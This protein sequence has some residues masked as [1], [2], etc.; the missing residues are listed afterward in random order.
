NALVVD[1]PD[2]IGAMHADITRLG[3]ALLNLLSNAAKFTEGGTVSLVVRR[4]QTHGLDFV[5]FTVRDTGIGMAQEQLEKLFQDFSQA[6]AS[7]TRKFG[8]TGLGLAIAR[9]FA[10][11]MGGDITVASVPGKGS[12]FELRL[13]TGIGEA[14][15]RPLPPALPLGRTDFAPLDPL[16]LPAE[17]AGVPVLVID[18]D[19]TVRDV[20]ARF[21]TRE[22]FAPMLAA[23]GLDGLRQAKLRKP[24]AIIL[25][26]MMPDLDG[27]SVLAAVKA[28]QALEDVPVVIHSIVE[29]KNRGFA[30]GASDYWVKPFDRDR[31]RH[32]L[33]RVRLPR[34]GGHALLVEDDEATRYLTRQILE[35][36]GWTVSEA[37]DGRAALEAA[38]AQAPDAIILDLMMPEMDGF[39]FL[40]ELRSRGAAQTVPVVV[41]TALTLTEADRTRLDGRVRQVVQKGAAS[42]DG[43]LRELRKLVGPARA[44]ENAA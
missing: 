1:C 41:V 17:T 13:P 11:M 33:E 39:E 37:A 14:G 30:L 21:L 2:D 7:T 36:E 18:D 26:I 40:A 31:L 42:R 34:G 25:D 38:E 23:D 32:F 28:D 43:L 15:A 22:G 24:A 9:R 5:S 44:Q 10:R 29:E 12:A 16:P 8:G 19:A 3:Q 35:A 6:D 20:L 27:W 4:T